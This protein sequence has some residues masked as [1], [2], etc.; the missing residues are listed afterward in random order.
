MMKKLFLLLLIFQFNA[1]LGQ[2]TFQEVIDEITVDE[3]DY[4]SLG[5]FDHAEEKQGVSIQ[6]EPQI[7]E[8]L[9][10]ER[11]AFSEFYITGKYEINNSILLFVSKY[12]LS[13]DIHSAILL[14]KSLNIIDRLDETAYVNAEGFYGVTT[15]IDYNIISSTIHN[16]YSTPEYV[17]KKYTITDNGFKA[18]KD[19]V[20]VQT[21]SGILIR[22]DPTIASTIVGSAADLDTFNYL[23]C[24]YELDS[25]AAFENGR[26]VKD[27]WFDVAKNDSFTHLGHVFGAFVKRQISLVTNDYHVIVNEISK[28]D[29]ASEEDKKTIK[30]AIEKITDID[31]ITKVLKGQLV[32][33]TSEYG[34]YLVKK[35]IADNGKEIIDH[36]DE[37]GIS[38]YFPSFH[39]L[40][41]EGGH[42]TELLIDLKNG[43][44]DI[45]RIGNPD[46]Y[47]PSPKNTFR[48]NGYYSGQSFIHFL[49]QNNADGE[50]EYLFSFPSLLKLD[51]IE[52]YFWKDDNTIFL[53]IENIYYSVQLQNL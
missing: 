37:I 13:E 45:D 16:I 2:K 48:L 27:F 10:L 22:E 36:W 5:Y 51:F 7:L 46:Y 35:I 38:A 14:D 15:S 33:D 4:F 32:G 50:P 41:L 34:Y 43:D 49:E 42:S 8:K 9:K 47:L 30:S 21:P 12:S 53:K 25:T 52:S 40:L 18:I 17:T 29:F 19:Q 26:F 6:N 44:Y 39:Y 11:S 23:S 24:G 1:V 3:L 31:E 28:E 20:I